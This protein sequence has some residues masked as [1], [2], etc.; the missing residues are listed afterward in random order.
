MIL[1]GKMV[2]EVSLSSANFFL[3]HDISVWG[4]AW[5]IVTTAVGTDIVLVWMVF[6][7]LTHPLVEWLARLSAWPWWSIVVPHR[8]VELHAHCRRVR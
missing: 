7:L 5:F 8:L 3:W 4:K 1:L 2:L 6:P